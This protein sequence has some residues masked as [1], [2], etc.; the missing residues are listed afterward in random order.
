M[1]SGDEVMG[2]LC[3]LEWEETAIFLLA[4]ETGNR[5]NLFRVF[6]GP[7]P[8]LDVHY[9]GVTLSGWKADSGSAIVLW[10][11]G[12]QTRGHCVQLDQK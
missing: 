1:S 12:A 10:P 3:L 9:F 11:Q 4:W 7:G 8:T 2:T 5:G 6:C